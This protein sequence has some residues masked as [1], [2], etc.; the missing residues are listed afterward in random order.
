[1][2]SLSFAPAG[3][4]AAHAV[5]QQPPMRLKIASTP[6]TDPGRFDTNGPRHADGCQFAVVNGH[7]DS[8]DEYEWEESHDWR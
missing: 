3:S 1:V 2:F 6:L 8:G 4:L 7:G 5:P